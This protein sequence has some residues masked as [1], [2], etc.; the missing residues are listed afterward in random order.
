[1]QAIRCFRGLF[2][3]GAVG[4]P[5]LVKRMNTVRGGLLEK[6][7]RRAPLPWPPNRNLSVSARACVSML[8]YASGQEALVTGQ[9]SAEFFQSALDLIDLPADE[10]ARL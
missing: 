3:G 2:D 6:L 9:P 7:L 8:E 5:R 1:M 4:S 10:P